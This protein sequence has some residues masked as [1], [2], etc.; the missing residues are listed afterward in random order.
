M[1]SSIFELESTHI[2][3]PSRITTLN[4]SQ[5]RKKGNVL[6]L[7]ERDMRIYGNHSVNLGY[8]LS[9]SNRSKFY[10]GH[11]FFSM[12]NKFQKQFQYECIKEMFEDAKRLNIYM[13]RIPDSEKLTSFL[14]NCKISHLIIDY[15]PMR[16]FRQNAKLLKSICGEL[17]INLIEC[18]SHNIVPCKLLKKYKKSTRGVKHDLYKRYPEFCVPFRELE[19]HKYNRKKETRLQN[20]GTD[21]DDLKL[22]GK[23]KKYNSKGGYSQAIEILEKFLSQH[24]KGFAAKRNNPNLNFRTFLDP[25]VHLGQL[26]TQEL[27]L[28]SIDYNK[29]NNIDPAESDTGDLY[30]FLNEIFVWKETTEHYCMHEKNHDNYDGASEWARS[31]LNNHLS[32]ERSGPY[33]L[34]ELDAS[35][36]DFELWNAAMNEL[37]QTGNQHPYIRIYWSKK[38]LFFKKTPEEAL[39][40]CLYLNNKYSLGA[41]GPNETVW[42]MYGI[43]GAMD[44]GFMDREVMGKVR[45]MQSVETRAGRYVDR[46]LF[47]LNL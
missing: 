44:Q 36:T 28:Y 15:S 40:D 4:E 45:P 12:Y 10:I 30:T 21:Y 13:N 7:M 18:D 35:E 25:Y 8:T 31:S 26:G 46:W 27:V 43:V 33:N 2:I 22:D 5:T 9:E 24:L 6:Y 38:F 16:E 47:G 19:P 41:Y 20:M 37:K 34:K 32:D 29:A 17:N 3:H 14:E 23:Q 42:I 1:K 39:K 11:M